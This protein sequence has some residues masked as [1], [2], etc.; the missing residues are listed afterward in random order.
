M[1]TG[2]IVLI[3]KSNREKDLQSAENCNRDVSIVSVISSH[4]PAK[5]ANIATAE[6]HFAQQCP[7][8]S[9]TDKAT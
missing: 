4:P 9:D 5:I 2:S 3:S 6:I 1:E 7:C 8:Y